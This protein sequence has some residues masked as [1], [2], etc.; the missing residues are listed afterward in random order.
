MRL[1]LQTGEYRPP[2]PFVQSALRQSAV[3]LTW[4]E[5]SADRLFAVSRASIALQTTASSGVNRALTLH[6]FEDEKDAMTLAHLI[7]GES[8]DDEEAPTVEDAECAFHIEEFTPFVVGN[9]EVGDVGMQDQVGV[10]VE[11]GLVHEEG[12]GSVDE[13]SSVDREGDQP[14]TEKESKLNENSQLENASKVQSVEQKKGA[15]IDP[16]EKYRQLMRELEEEALPKEKHKQNSKDTSTK[17]HESD[18]ESCSDDD[19]R[20]EVSWD[21]DG[22]FYSLLMIFLGYFRFSS[23]IKIL[24]AIRIELYF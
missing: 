5:T 4:D 1:S 12:V 10:G 22:I 21:A 15:D 8:D 3:T 23:L 18:S 9:G 19:F 20:M 11:G 7:A 17:K 24:H 14:R 6:A 13:V 2:P 16:V